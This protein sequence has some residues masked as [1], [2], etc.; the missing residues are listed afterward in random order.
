MPVAAQ[1]PQS[2]ELFLS[3]G[4]IDRS[5]QKSAMSKFLTLKD[6]LTSFGW[7]S[8]PYYK[9]KGQGYLGKGAFGSVQLAFKMEDIDQAPHRRRLAALKTQL[10]KFENYESIWV[11]L[12]VMKSVKHDNIVQFYDA[13]AEVSSPVVEKPE[14]SKKK[15]GP[16]KPSSADEKFM[17]DRPDRWV[18]ATSSTSGG[19]RKRELH[20]LGHEGRRAPSAPSWLQ[21]LHPEPPKDAP[22][23]WIIMEYANAGSLHQRIRSYPNHCLPE[24]TAVMFAKQI[25]SAVAY[26]HSKKII[27]NDLHTGNIL[28]NY[29]NDGSEKCLL[30]D[31]GLSLIHGVNTLF[32][33]QWNFLIEKDIWSIKQI[34]EDMQSHRQPRGPATISD[35]VRD[36]VMSDVNSAEQLLALPWFNQPLGAPEAEDRRKK[37]VQ[38]HQP[39]PFVKEEKV[40]PPT[41]PSVPYERIIHTPFGAVSQ[42][43][44]AMNKLLQAPHLRALTGQS[45]VQAH[46]P[47]VV[48]IPPKRRT[49]DQATE[50]AGP[51]PAS[52]DADSRARHAMEIDYDNPQPGPS[53]IGR[54]SSQLMPPPPPPP[55][56]PRTP[57]PP[58]RSP[59]TPSPPSPMSRSPKSKSPQK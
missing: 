52:P 11:E 54:I 57:S 27:H 3:S 16:A 44:K 33:S 39:P 50:Q 25:V 55:R 36:L 41:D 40:P 20:D 53:G 56:S 12:C 5:G 6:G 15:F 38:A 24:L 4:N 9:P 30:C 13:F 18:P 32:H 29:K 19:K 34:V 22:K 23:F 47:S 59:R 51:P 45:D 43:L 46:W 14:T 49:T 35:A 31:F 37:V 17:R 21:P 2:L 58:P 8:W 26:L 28:L 42:P 7:S 48:R 1:M 10:L